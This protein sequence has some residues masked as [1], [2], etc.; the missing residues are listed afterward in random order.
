MAYENINFRKA[1]MT[2][3]GNYF[4][5]MD[6]NWDELV[7]KLD[8]GS[9]AFSYPLNS[10]LT[11]VVVS[12]EYDGVN[13]WSMQDISGGVTIKRWQIENNIVELKDTFN[14]T[15]NFDSD[16]FT[17]EHYHDTLASGITASGTVIYLNNY[18]SVVS[19]G[20]SLTLGPNSSSQYEEVDVNTVSGSAIILVSGTQNSY[21][22][23]DAVNFYNHIWIFNSYSTGSLHKIDAYTGANLNTYNDSEYDSITACTFARVKVS[24]TVNTLA[25]VKSVNLKFLNINTLVPYGVMTIDNL[26]ADNSTEIVVYDLAVYGGN[27]YRLQKEATYYGVD[28]LWTN[29]SYVLSTTRRF[30]DIV[31]ISAYPVILPANAVNV[32]KITMLVDDQYGDGVYN[33]PVFFVDDDDVGFMTI[34]PAYTDYF[35]GTGEAISYYKAGV[36]VRT[37]NIEGTATQYD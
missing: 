5:M 3:D 13:F 25:Y 10:L 22:S 9:V 16:A 30:L 26:R 2:F 28:N 15:P 19:S 35:F 24:S 23:G 31:S 7:Q 33:K 14:F 11:S 34:N 6:D 1:N 21:D 20:I 18:T 29:Y 36:E 4:Y 37:V 32:T 27:I 12:L 8:D 17:V